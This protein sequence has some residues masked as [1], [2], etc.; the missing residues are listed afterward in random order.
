M[1]I[2]GIAQCLSKLDFYHNLMPSLG[3]KVIDM[4]AIERLLII[5][6][7][8]NIRFAMISNV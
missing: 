3:I 2:N 4:A 7:Q 6:T 5:W 8:N 1:C